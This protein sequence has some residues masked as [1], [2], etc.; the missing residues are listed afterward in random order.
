MKI[1]I[2]ETFFRKKCLILHFRDVQCIFKNEPIS[3]L[4]EYLI[5]CKRNVK[6]ILHRNFNSFF[7]DDNPKLEINQK[8]TQKS[9]SKKFLLQENYSPNFLKDFIRLCRNTQRF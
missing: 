6:L 9:D 3:S 2:G 4:G 5:H 7:T 1:V 8:F